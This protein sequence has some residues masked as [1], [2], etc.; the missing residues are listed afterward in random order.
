MSE[1]NDALNSALGDLHK[2]LKGLEQGVEAAIVATPRLFQQELDTF[3]V[4]KLDLTADEFL[5]SVDI[6]WDG[7]AIVVEIDDDN[8]LANALETGVEGWDM[9]E[10]HLNS[11][12]AKFSS[13]GWKYLTIPIEKFPSS[14]GGG[15]SKSQYYHNLVKEALVDPAFTTPKMKMS[16]D[17]TVGTS[18]RL[19]TEKKDLGGFY[20]MKRYKDQEL[21]KPI[22][23]QFI[24]FRTMSNHPK[25][26]D[27]W[28]HPGLRGIN[29]FEHL[30]IWSQTQYGVLI[31]NM[32]DYFVDNNVNL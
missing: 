22:S 24:M 21:K 30:E 23:T 8:W 11:P 14:R 28:L 5:N 18:E 12:K 27:K 2:V 16:L 7:G 15:T 31:E 17:G 20:R 1:I 3:V 19:I 4:R 25:Q 13:Q 9:K 6:Y 32:L 10:T 29:S 26:K